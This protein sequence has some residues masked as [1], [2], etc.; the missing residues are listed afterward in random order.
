[1]IALRNATRERA[2]GFLPLLATPASGHER[3]IYA[4]DYAIVYTSSGNW[5]E[6]GIQLVARSTADSPWD[7]TG[8]PVLRQ[9]VASLVTTDRS[10]VVVNTVKTASRCDDYVA[11]LLTVTTPGPSTAVMIRDHIVKRAF[12]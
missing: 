7:M 4:F 12:L 3:S 10:D 1:M 2:F 9:L 8:R 6:N 5:R 11:R